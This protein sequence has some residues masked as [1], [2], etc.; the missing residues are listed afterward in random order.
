MKKVV[1]C[2]FAFVLLLFGNNIFAQSI[3]LETVNGSAPND[4]LPVNQSIVFGLHITGTASTYAG[5][6]NGFRVYSPEG[7]TWSSMSGDTLPLGWDSWF[8][9]AFSINEFSTGSGADTVGFGGAKLFSTGLPANFDQ[10]SYEITIGPIDPSFHKDHLCLDSS[11]YQPTGVWK[12]A[13]PTDF[14]TWDGPHCFVI[15]D[16]SAP[17]D[18][19]NIVLSTDSLYFS[20]SQG[21]A[22]PPSQTF[23]I[24]TDLDQFNFTL[25][26]SASWFFPSPVV[27]TTPKTIDVNI[28]ILGLTEGIYIDSIEVVAPVTDNSPQWVKIVLEVLPPPPTIAVNVTNLLF[29]AVAGEANP[30]DKFFNISNV[31]GG[32][33]NWTVS[34][35][36]SWLSM[37]PASGTNSDSVTVSIDITGLGFNDYYD[38]IIVSDPAATNDPVEIPVLL[39]VGSDLP[40]IQVDSQFNYIIV[41]SGLTSIPNRDILVSNGGAGAMSFTTSESSTRI[42]TVTPSAGNAPQVVS[43]GFKISGGVPGVD[44][45]DT[46]WVSSPEALNSPVPVVFQFHYVNTPAQIILNRDTVTLNVFECSQGITNVLVQDFFNISNVS[47]GEP[48][49]FDLLWE[50]DYVTV[51]TEFG[52]LPEFVSV[53]AKYPELPLGTYYDTIT[54]TAVNAINSPQSVIVRYNVVSGLQSPQINLSSTNYTIPTME[55]EGPVPGAVL[56]VNN[57]FGGCMPWELASVPPFMYPDNTSG[58]VPGVVGFNIHASGFP[59][60]QYTDTFYVEAPGAINNPRAVTIT[61]KVWKFRGDFNYDA[62]LNIADLVAFVEYSFASG[63]GPAP[64]WRVGDVNCDHLVNIADIVYMV[65]YMFNNGPIPCGNPYK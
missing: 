12:W 5:M 40:L 20:A 13:G 62:N 42:F 64:E 22:N 15:I 52:Q 47:G 7:A 41:P 2:M 61:M 29:N 3:Y 51:E 63:P 46:L 45:F 36:Q 14:P 32:D 6:T 8:D 30:A 28:N 49:T 48:Y 54:V 19:S 39:S 57:T 43:V 56:K 10:L 23:D 27:G 60:G 53:V 59:F 1:F 24:L 55:N 17:A 34:N 58:D 65:D 21:G 44:Y 37:T 35:S 4:T 26:E 33:L 18:P 25:N 31:G 11:F 9:L 38:T 50:S 16:P